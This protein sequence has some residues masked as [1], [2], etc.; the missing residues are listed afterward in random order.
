MPRLEL[1]VG[2]I[3]GEVNIGYHRL[4][5]E[6]K[7]PTI[8]AAYESTQITKVVSMGYQCAHLFPFEGVLPQM[9]VVPKVPKGNEGSFG[10]HYLLPVKPREGKLAE[11]M[12]SD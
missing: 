1:L 6:L 3:A 12:S 7:R 5:I 9:F 2:P 4:N 8:A 10:L 11:N